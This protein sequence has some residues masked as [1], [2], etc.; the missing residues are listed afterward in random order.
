M[1]EIVERSQNS[2]CFHLPS[3]TSASSHFKCLPPKTPKFTI[4]WDKTVTV[5]YS[6]I[7]FRTTI[8]IVEIILKYKS[9][10]AVESFKF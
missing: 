5:V 2:K 4:G 10:L 1:T 7:F 9:K 8:C 6:L 3:K